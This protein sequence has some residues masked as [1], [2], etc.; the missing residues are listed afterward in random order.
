MDAAW[1]EKA[2]D[3]QVLDEVKRQIDV[4]GPEKFILSV[5]SPLTPGTSLERVRLFCGSTRLV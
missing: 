4:A 1:L 3:Q 5:G 2:T